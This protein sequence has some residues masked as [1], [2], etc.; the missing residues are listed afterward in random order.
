MHARVKTDKL[1]KGRAT[2]LAGEGGGQFPEKSAGK[3]ILQGE[4]CPVFTCSLT[5]SRSQSLRPLNQRSRS[6]TAL[7]DSKTGTRNFFDV[8]QISRS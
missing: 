2:T 1:N 5:E 7:G 8:N 4:P 6:A 3:K